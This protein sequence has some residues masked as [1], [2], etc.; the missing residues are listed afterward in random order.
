MLSAMNAADLDTA[1]TTAATDAHEHGWVTESSHTTSDGRIVYVRCV[2]CGARRVDAAH[3]GLPPTAIA[4]VVWPA[5]ASDNGP[6]PSGGSSSLS[7]SLTSAASS[8]AVS[9][10]GR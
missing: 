2:A 3:P 4:R 1:L 7:T 8:N 10:A 6:H 9:E 5:D